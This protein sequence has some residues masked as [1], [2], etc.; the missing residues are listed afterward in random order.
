MWS[1]RYSIRNPSTMVLVTGAGVGR[2]P[3]AKA[4]E[5]GREAREN[6]KKHQVSF[7]SAAGNSHGQIADRDMSFSFS[8]VPRVMEALGMPTPTF[9]SG[10]NVRRHSHTGQ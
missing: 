2:E 10:K 4:E 3:L 8:Q 6:I 7:D 9:P 5:R 1:R